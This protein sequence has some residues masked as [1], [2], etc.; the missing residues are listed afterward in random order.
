VRIYQAEAL[1]GSPPVLFVQTSDNGP[2]T[3]LTEG[4]PPTQQWHLPP[5]LWEMQDP[6][7]S[8]NQLLD[9]LETKVEAAD[10]R[11]SAV[12]AVQDLIESLR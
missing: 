5:E 1:Q 9:E 7:E 2:I 6:V 11:P 10:L 12:S 8:R 3:V 4:Q